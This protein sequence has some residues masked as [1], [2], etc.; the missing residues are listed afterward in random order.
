M[1]SLPKLIDNHHETSECVAVKREGDAVADDEKDE[2]DEQSANKYQQ[3][4]C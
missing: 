2:E 4:R 1:D 3:Q